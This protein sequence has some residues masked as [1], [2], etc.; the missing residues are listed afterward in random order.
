MGWP[1]RGRLRNGVRLHASDTLRFMNV[2]V[3]RGNFYGTSALVGLLERVA[4]RVDTLMPG[5]RLNVGELLE[6]GRWK[7][8]RTPLA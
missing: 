1:W 4:Q 8:H 7:Y 3:P 5:A 6:A 2:D